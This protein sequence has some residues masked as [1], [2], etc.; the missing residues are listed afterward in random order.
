MV[1]RIFDILFSL[2]FLL[3]F[4]PVLL[5]LEIDSVCTQIMTIRSGRA[6]S[7]NKAFT[8]N[9][10]DYITVPQNLDVV[11]Y[12]S[13]LAIQPNMTLRGTTIASFALLAY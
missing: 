4:A 1:K 13:R 7:V 10:D 8:R 6:A 2:V 12:R 9:H 3:L 11:S 5:I